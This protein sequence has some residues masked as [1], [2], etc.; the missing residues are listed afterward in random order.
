MEVFDPMILG[1]GKNI[2]K[3]IKPKNIY[4][5]AITFSNSKNVE[6]DMFYN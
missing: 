5:Y 6:I 1:E 2:V 3:K 4:K